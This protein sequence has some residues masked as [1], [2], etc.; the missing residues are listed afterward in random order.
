M[1]LAPR[2]LAPL[3][4]ALALAAGAPGARAALFDDDEARKAILD[5]RARVQSN[6]EAARKERA[7]QTEQLGTL[8]RSLL[9]LS[10]QIEAMRSEIARLRGD[11]EQLLRELSLLQRAQKDASQSL[12]ERLRKLEPQTVAVDGREFAAAADEKRAY[13]DAVA[14]IRAGDFDGAASALAAFQASYPASGYTA[15]SRF[16]LGNALY[17]KRDYKG[18]I[19]AFRALVAD[20]PD[21]ARAPEALLAVANSQAEMKDPR[22]AR[23]TLDELIKAYP[24]SEAAVAGKERL[25]SLR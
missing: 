17:A 22:A 11:N 24:K 3:L 16:W 18:A 25:A 2:G 19:A 4:L 10:G 23:R 9:D 7:E 14:R 5:L 21:H 20:T 6:E 15:S 13:E 8:R 12:D 1:A